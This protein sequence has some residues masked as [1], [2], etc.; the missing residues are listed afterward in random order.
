[1][2]PFGLT[3]FGFNAMRLA[4]IKQSLED[5]FIAQFGDINLDPQSVF[6][7]EIGVL[8]KSFA[9]LW[10][11]LEDVYFSQYPN[12]ASGVSLDNVVQLNGITRLP[13]TQTSVTATCDGIEGTYI[14][15]NSLARISATG[16]NFFANIGGFITQQN[17]DIVS[18]Q[19]TSPPIAQP[20][21]VIISNQVYTYARPT[22]N[23]ANIGPIFV[24]GNVITVFL[25]GIAL[26]SV[27][28][29]TSSNNT[30]TLIYNQIL[31]FPTVD[32]STSITNPN[33]ISIFSLLG[34]NTNVTNII[35][36]GGAT[37]ATYTITYTAPPS[38]NAISQRLTA[39]I[40][41]AAAS[42]TAV[43]NTG[44]N[45]T[46]TATNPAVPFSINLGPGMNVYYVA[47]PINFLCVD[48]GPISCPV[49]ALDTIVTPIA[50]WQS[51][52][53]SV[54]GVTGTL[55]ETDA[56][57]R[58]RR[59]NSIHILGLATVEA[60][61]S[62]LQQ[63]SGVISALV[64]EN[65]TLLQEPIIITFPL[66]FSAGDVI[67]V[68]YNTL[69]SFTVT[70][71]TNQATTMG[72][73]V[74]AFEDLPAVSSA[75]YGGPGNQVLT[76]NMNILM[77][78]VV[79][80]VVTSVSS[81]TAIITGGRPPKSF[82]AV[83]EGG[84]DENI[85]NTI[86]EAK[87]A[88]IETYGNTSYTITDSQ[89]DPQVIFFSRPTPIYIWVTCALTLYPEETF[90]PN[91]TSLVAAAI[92]SYGN[93]LGIGVDVLFQ[94]VLAQIFTVSGIASGNMSIAAT[95]DLVT[96][97]TYGTSDIIIA[98]NQIS[99]FDLSRIFITVV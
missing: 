21:N 22:I 95:F 91:G 87:P 88:G 24:S 31:L 37:Q 17:A 49:S 13:A 67:T 14:P 15:I 3:P 68:T 5:A 4:D 56:Q 64:F 71:S 84:S 16:Q 32:P 25:N 83:V 1:M 75:S 57:L 18:V 73:L 46:V 77:D 79:N 35:I 81:Q 66:V 27:T 36:T 12:S 19:A 63:V 34:F 55:I 39:I 28:Y 47:S 59:F 2:T 26:P 38:M 97:P 42:Y 41:Q 9:D 74:T 98:E 7:Q 45:F 96:S 89:G 54:A 11:N 33:Q 76:V 85:A 58:I 10:E 43:D 44:G 80:S 82:E 53:N 69:S 99:I 23:F 78:L 52:N 62:R 72:L 48:Y 29:A 51:I 30:L 61:R 20:Y 40:N 93:S 70:Y 92:N 86:W 50:G 94:R 60:I 90:P 8:S 65:Y 6:G